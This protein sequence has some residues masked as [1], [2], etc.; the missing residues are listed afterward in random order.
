VDVWDGFVDEAGRFMQQGPDFEGQTRR[1]RTSDGVFFTKAGARKM[2]H[3][4]DREIKRLLSNR[5]VP[6]AL[7]S[8][9]GTP[10]TS[11]KPGLPAPRP[12]AGPIL[13]LIAS[14]VGTNELLGG[15][16][17]RPA[18]VDALA[19]RTLIKGEPLAAPGGRA[20]DS[21]SARS[22]ARTTFRSPP[23][24]RLTAP[25]NRRRQQPRIR[26]RSP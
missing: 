20:D 17:T 3:Y 26:R 2:A 23:A 1:L 6:V 21:R 16:G 13:P 8:D 25:C 18:A 22:T 7:P 5:A 15:A 14:S 4:V 10:D 11:A 9:P 12:L 19:A 24:R